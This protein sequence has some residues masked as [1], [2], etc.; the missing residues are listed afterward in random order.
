MK[1]F[2]CCF[3]VAAFLF[4]AGAV[5][6][7]KIVILT[8][9]ISGADGLYFM[10]ALGNVH[11][12]GESST[13]PSAARPEGAAPDTIAARARA[14]AGPVAGCTKI[15]A[16]CS[17][18]AV[19]TCS[20]AFAGARAVAGLRAEALFRAVFPG[21]PS[22]P[23]LFSFSPIFSAPAR[24]KAVSYICLAY[25]NIARAGAVADHAFPWNNGLGALSRSFM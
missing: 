17:C 25:I 22:F 13:A 9:R 6:G 10:E 7:A 11:V 2:F 8:A 5:A 12:Y 3:F 1:R 14:V 19:I 15:G 24:A 20:E 16:G 4:F 18:H 21:R 23:E